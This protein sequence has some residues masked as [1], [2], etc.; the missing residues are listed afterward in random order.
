M[1][2]KD[3][4]LQ[5]LLRVLAIHLRLDS[6]FFLWRVFLFASKVIESH[7][8]EKKE[9]CNATEGPFAFKAWCAPKSML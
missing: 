2:V 5:A 6:A 7:S 8:H 1:V 9:H 3:G 4:G